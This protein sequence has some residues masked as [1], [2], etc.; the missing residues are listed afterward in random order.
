MLAKLWKAVG[1]A[2]QAGQLVTSTSLG[3][4]T[5]RCGKVPVVLDHL[6]GAASTAKGRR[7]ESGGF[8]EEAATQPPPCGQPTWW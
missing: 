5:Y 4:A 7:I 8:M 3:L 1:P 2:F 6:M